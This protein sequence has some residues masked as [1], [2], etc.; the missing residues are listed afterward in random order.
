VLQPAIDS[1][2][3][4]KKSKDVAA[5]VKTWIK[6][7]K[8]VGDLVQYIER[9]KEN[10]ENEDTVGVMAAGLPTFEDIRKPFLAQ[11]AAY[12]D[13]RT[14][15]DDFVIGENYSGY[16][17]AIFA[18]RYDLRSGGILP[19]GKVGEHTA[20]FIKATLSGGVYPNSW[21]TP[22][23]ALKY[24]LKGNSGKFDENRS[25]NA[26]VIQYPN[27]P[28]E[29]TVQSPSEPCGSAAAVAFGLLPE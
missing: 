10:V 3:T 23:L 1:E 2:V 14:R 25:E 11:F 22:D 24:Y 6:Q 28:V 7:F 4:P 27:V 20:V 26:A 17:I 9:F 5:H 18:K 13:D 21:I 29:T 8:R 15:L 19:I 12:G 16:D